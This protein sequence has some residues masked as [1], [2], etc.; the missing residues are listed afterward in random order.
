MVVL[1]VL[2]VTVPTGHERCR[3]QAGQLGPAVPLSAPLAVPPPPRVAH[4][5]SHHDA[6]L[7]APLALAVVV[8]DAVNKHT[9][10]MGWVAGRGGGTAA[11]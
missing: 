5:P 1:V 11:L 8:L 3:P 7:E 6:P 2:V 9:D 4:P 10:I